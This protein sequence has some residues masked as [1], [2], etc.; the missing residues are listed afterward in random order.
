MRAISGPEHPL[1]L[2]L[3]DLQWIDPASLNLIH[4][5]LTD[6][7]QSHLLIVGAY[8]DNEVGSAHL[9]TAALDTL[10]K[11]SVALVELTLQPLA[12]ESVTSLLADTLDQPADAVDPLA[13]ALHGKTQGNPF[14]LGQYLAELVAEKTLWFD[15]DEQR[16]RWNLQGVEKRVVAENVVALVMAKLRRLPATTQHVVTLAAAIGHQFD[17]ATLATISGMPLTDTFAALW[18]ALETSVAL[19]VGEDYRFL[20]RRPDADDTDTAELRPQDVWF[21]FLHDRIQQA[22]YALTPESQ[23]PGLHLRIGRLL[24]ERHGGP[25]Q[26]RPPALFEVARHLGRGVE[27]ISDPEER[28]T[29]ARLDLAAGRHAKAASAYE[30]AT[31]FFSV[32]TSLLTPAHWD[33]DYE[34]AFA[35]HAEHAA[36]EY[37]SGRSDAAEALLAALI[38]RARTDFHYAELCT[39]RATL[40]ATQGRLADVIDWS[41]KGLE[42]LGISLPTAPEAQQAAFMEELAAAAQNLGGR[43]V[44]ELLAAPTIDD[45]RV[46]LALTILSEMTPTCMFAA[47]GLYGPVLM[48][49]VNLSLKHGHTRVSAFGYVTY[50]FLLVAMLGQYELGHE[51]GRLALALNE[52][53]QNTR[54]TCQIHVGFAMGLHHNRPLREAIEHNRIG[55]RAG[56][57]SGDINIL[58]YGCYNAIV[59]RF[60]LGDELMAVGAELE[61][62]LEIATRAGETLSAMQM[63]VVKQVIA[64]L[65][66]ETRGLGLGSDEFDEERFRVEQELKGPTPLL[67]RYYVFKE[68][69]HYLHGDHYR[70]LEEGERAERIVHTLAGLHE[71]TMH[72]FYLALT[73]LALSRTASGELRSAYAERIAR[74]QE[75]MAGWAKH[76]P[77]NF[78]HRAALLRAEAADVAGDDEAPRLYEQA[79]E[80]AERSGF[81]SDLALASELAALHHLGRGRREPAAPLLHAARRSYARWG[82]NAKVAQLD[83]RHRALLFPD[84]PPQERYIDESEPVVL[85]HADSSFDAMTVLKV[86]QALAGE[87]V[88]TK[89]IEQIMATVTTRAGAQRGA[90]ILEQDGK[91][92]IEAIISHDPDIVRVDVREPLEE[93]QI[94]ATSIVRYVAHT[95]ETVVLG[96]ASRVE[97]FGSDRYITA[98]RPKSVLCLALTHRGR[99]IGLIYL[100][101]NLAANVFTVEQVDLI[102]MLAAHAAIS[103]QN[104]LLYANVER[105]TAELRVSNAELSEVNQ[106][107][108]AELLERERAEHERTRLQ[109]EVIAVQNA[110]LAELSTPLI[111]ISDQIMVMPIIG[112]V[113][114]NRANRL[115]EAALEGAH[116]SRA[117]VVI[118]DITGLKQIDLAAAASLMR[119]ARALRLLGS[120]V[121]ITGIRAD[122]AQTLIGLGIDLSGVVTRGTLQDGIAHAMALVG[123]GKQRR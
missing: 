112:T 75:T 46:E 38:P 27:R 77:E 88:L 66:G 11:S 107:L 57:E 70:A 29:L 99:L 10:R 55:Y 122:I 111:P 123:A 93:S 85:G 78:E 45:P 5:L 108:Q 68:M 94:L 72:V 95:R 118:L 91:L 109:E 100:E 101:N 96:D 52:R 67:A 13:R 106:R 19:P 14:F 60:A 9:L 105:I 40:H 87:I 6:G 17:A 31:S 15:K 69:L 24:L 16:W 39:L 48:K 50:G 62:F 80:A 49:Q 104:A 58:C 23:L 116:G 1:V 33:S 65:Q 82:A 92:M 34:L 114:D 36:C 97:R 113:D 120:A 30:S 98:N 12:L 71:H 83:Q 47:P 102:R 89:L 44:A 21:K 7:E 84:G 110:R 20:V 25:E 76:C 18:P 74:C 121:V 4:A 32:G 28:L 3:D 117:A 51:F 8:R 61:Q 53:F 43:S 81:V 41:L 90:L 86:A 63:T 103:V 42:R 2:F 22:A 35:L 59:F 26:L 79:I 73:L 115:V 37:L 64:S 54:L 56:L 119:T